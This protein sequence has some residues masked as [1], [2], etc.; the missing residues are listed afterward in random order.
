LALA[1]DADR[2]A[3]EHARRSEAQ[4]ERRRRERRYSSQNE[5]DNGTYG[6]Q[7]R[8]DGEQDKRPEFVRETVPLTALIGAPTPAGGFGDDAP[9][10]PRRRL[11]PDVVSGFAPVNAA[12]S[13][14]GPVYDS[15]G[16][17]VERPAPPVVGTLT[18]DGK[19]E[20]LHRRSAA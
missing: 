7:V 18:P 6:E 17:R 4:R 3:G 8:T 12:G 9:P 19:L 5:A 15:Y 14:H 2:R 11:L 10:P 20:P 16:D 13:L 1:E